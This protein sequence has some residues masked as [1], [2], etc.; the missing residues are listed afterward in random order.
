MVPITVITLIVAFCLQTAKPMSLVWLAL[1]LWLAAPLVSA[2]PGD[3][4]LRWWPVVSPWPALQRTVATPWPRSLCRQVLVW[5]VEWVAATLGV[6]VG[7]R[8]MGWLGCWPS[9]ITG[10]GALVVLYGAWYLDPKDPA[11]RPLPSAAVHGRCPL[12]AWCWPT[13]WCCW[14]CSGSS[15]ACRAF[16]HRLL[17]PPAGRARGGAHGTHHYRCRWSVSV[18]GCAAHRPD[19]VG[20]YQLDVVLGARAVCCRNML[21]SRWRWCL[22]WLGAFTKSAQFPFHF[23]LPHAMGGAYPRQR[24]PALGHHGQGRGVPAVARFYPLLGGNEWWFWIVSSVGLITLLLGAYVAVFQHDLKGLLAY[25]TISHLGLITLLFRW[26]SRWRLWRVFSTS[27]TTPR[28]RWS[29]HRARGST[30]RPHA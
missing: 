23:W 1:R 29:V 24:L 11:P 14:S 15:P 17:E 27:S 5:R 8:L 30:T 21:C 25:S 13:I 4:A 3:A 6:G 28:S 9:C 10:I 18:C 12:L 2:L 7:F 16:A 26:M 20:S 19:F 22:Y